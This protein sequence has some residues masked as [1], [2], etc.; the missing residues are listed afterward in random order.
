MATYSHCSRPWNSYKTYQEDWDSVNM[1]RRIHALFEPIAML[2][3][4]FLS[5]H[6]G[7]TKPL[8]TSSC[9][10]SAIDKPQKS[11]R[12]TCL[13]LRGRVCLYIVE[14]NVVAIGLTPSS[15]RLDDLLWLDTTHDFR[16]VIACNLTFFVSIVYIYIV[17]LWQQKSII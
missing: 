8:S 14:C 12:R 7:R 17:R 15:S 4:Y 16:I 5:F 10:P 11:T 3:R 2:L 13:Q 6:S 1:P 9:S